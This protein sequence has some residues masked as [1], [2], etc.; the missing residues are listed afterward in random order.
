MHITVDSPEAASAFMLWLSV[1]ISFIFGA[2]V[3]SFLNV[4]IYRLPRNC[5]SI[6]RP[7]H[8]FCKACKKDIFWYDN[9]PIIS[10]FVLGGK[11]RHCGAKFSI[12]YAAIELLTAV[13]FGCLAYRFVAW[14][15]RDPQWEMLFIGAV[16]TGAFIVIFFIDVDF[17]IIPNEI[18]IPGII[19]AP[20]ISFLI[21]ALHAAAMPYLQTV[22]NANWPSFTAS[23]EKMT[24]PVL[25]TPLFGNVAAF[26]HSIAGMCVGGAIIWSL[27]ILGGAV[28]KKTLEQDE[29]RER[30]ELGISEEE[31]EGDAAKPSLTAMGFGDVKLMAMLGGLFGVIG[32]FSIL[33]V[34]VLSA[35]LIGAPIRLFYRKGDAKVPFG[36]FLVGGAFVY[37]IAGDRMLSFAWHLPDLMREYRSGFV[38]GSLAACALGIILLLALRRRRLKD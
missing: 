35:T 34:G 8:S 28:F 25:G 6:I 13:L 4:C 18:N 12:R 19:A 5:L 27:G 22:F 15:P 29:A 11:C 20:V 10:W 16:L 30:K 21:P 1:P 17:R 36:P 2:A 7:K 9:I 32:V 26:A 33:V 23:L 37:L 14:Q 38:A 24:A 31:G 3:G